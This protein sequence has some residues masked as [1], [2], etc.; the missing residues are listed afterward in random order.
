MDPSIGMGDVVL[1]L[2]LQALKFVLQVAIPCRHGSSQLFGC[3]ETDLNRIGEIAELLE[4]CKRSKDDSWLEV[5]FQL[6]FG[7]RFELEPD[8]TLLLVHCKIWRNLRGG[9]TIDRSVRTER[10]KS[11]RK[12][13]LCLCQISKTL[14]D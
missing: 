6:G 8:G 3:I 14:L 13:V 5:G 7:L 9:G 10:T 12:A 4:L 11:L 1:C 2:L